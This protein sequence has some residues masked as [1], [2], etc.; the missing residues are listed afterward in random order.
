MARL[1]R[2]A[3]GKLVRHVEANKVEFAAYS[4]SRAAR[5]LSQFA[6]Q[7]I[8]RKTVCEIY[9]ACDLQNEERKERRRSINPGYKVT[10]ALCCDYINLCRDLGRPVPEAVQR[11]AN[12]QAAEAASE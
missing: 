6:G 9:D 5:V 10:R 12:G 3:F 8:N 11:C 1:T 2:S 4:Q 7:N